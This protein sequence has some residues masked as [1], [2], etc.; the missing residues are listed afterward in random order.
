MP[1]LTWVILT[2]FIVSKVLSVKH[3]IQIHTSQLCDGVGIAHFGQSVESS[4]H[5]R[6]GV[7]GALRLGHHVLHANALEDGTHGT[8][9]DDTGTRSS[10]LDVDV[11]AAV[12][13]VLLVRQRAVQNGN[14]HQV[15]L[16]VIN[17][18]LD[19]GG[20]FLGLAKTVT[21]DAVLI[22][23]DNLSLDFTLFTLTS[24]M[25]IRI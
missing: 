1:L 2:F 19:G 5:H 7:G 13:T 18:L 17:A 4:L 10:G 12:L 11:G 25:T 8:T 24:A 20:G 22:A 14:L 16:G 15:L 23:D 3:S 21:D 9:G 6:V